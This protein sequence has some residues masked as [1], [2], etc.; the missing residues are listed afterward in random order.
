M[1]EI[2]YALLDFIFPEL[3]WCWWHIIKQ[4]FHTF[5]CLILKLLTLGNII[6]NK[7]AWNICLLLVYLYPCLVLGL[8][9]S[10]LWALF[11]IFFLIIN[12]QNRHTCFI[13][14]SLEY[15]VFWMITC[16]KKAN[17]FQIAKVEPMVLLNFYLFFC[18]IQLG[19]VYKC[20]L[21]KKRVYSNFPFCLSENYDITCYFVIQYQHHKNSLFQKN[22]K[23]RGKF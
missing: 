1:T 19:T 13:T 23:N 14:H 6:F 3:V 7:L 22:I 12:V 9:M 18:R 20:C 11:F 15:A 2:C 5:F 8:F 17:N 21:Q 4:I 16:M 10:Y